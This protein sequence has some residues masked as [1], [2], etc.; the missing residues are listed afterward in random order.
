M[1]RILLYIIV[2]AAALLV[3]ERGT[4]VGELIPVELVFLYKDEGAIVLETD[5]GN[6][7]RGETLEAAY[8]DLKDTAPGIIFLDAADYLLV[9]RSVRTLAP[10]MAEYMKAGSRICQA[11][12]GIDL[13]LAAQYL[14]VHPSEVKLK[15]VEVA[16]ELPVLK[17]EKYGEK[18]ILKI[19]N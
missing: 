13:P 16:T 19:C 1:K 12:K 11:E 4:D 9:A 8:A 7:G 5:T 3:P 6:M 18:I 10:Q 14:N 17:Q 2:M 15:E